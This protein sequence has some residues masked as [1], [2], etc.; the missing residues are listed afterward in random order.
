MRC[1]RLTILALEPYAAL[2]HVSFL[3]G[4]ARHS[5][6]T[7]Q[8]A[9]L[10]AR[11]WKWR[12]RTASL[13][14]APLVR[15]R[16][17]DLLLVSDYVNLAELRALL[18]AGLSTL[19]AVIYFHENQLTYP[20]Q[21]TEAVDYHFAMTHFHALLSAQQAL[22]NSRYHQHQFL[23]ELPRLLALVPDVRL[24]DELAEASRRC[25]VLRMGT[26]VPVK[27]SPRARTDE[28]IV[29]WNHRWEYDKGPAEFV[30]ALRALDRQGERFRVRL[31][32]ARFRT[33]PEE[34][35]ELH[36]TLAH[37]LDPIGFIA[38]R[39][40]YLEALAAGDLVV[41]TAL[42]EFFGLGVLEAMR[43]GLAPVLPNDLAYPELLPESGELHGHFLYPREGGLE[44]A[45]AQ[46][47]GG[48]RTGALDAPR[49]ALAIH[50]R[51][52]DWSVVAPR[53]DLVFEE[54]MG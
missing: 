37:R 51:S 29:V 19:P 28:P 18:P 20:L 10:P 54:S 43:L 39:E 2:S 27:E 1:P 3:D 49:R 9:T 31:L 25:R 32:G 12:M 17:P 48:I 16:K 22:F 50:L 33:V 11:K 34:F 5:R 14:F 35:R 40:A 53:F 41:S 24:D 21:P 8:I 45:L 23:N 6:H 30:A 47:L 44:A 7:I 36:D 52:Y 38:E 4:L 26:D 13:H 42:H 46:A 15:E